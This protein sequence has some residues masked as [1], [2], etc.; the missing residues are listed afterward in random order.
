MAV[1]GDGEGCLLE[2][3]KVG[4]FSNHTRIAEE[5]EESA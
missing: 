5:R 2:D 1:L 4:G 3:Y